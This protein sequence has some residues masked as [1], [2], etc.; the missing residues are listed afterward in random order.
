MAPG[1][2]HGDRTRT[3]L[4]APGPARGPKGRPPASTRTGAGDYDYQ[5]KTGYIVNYIGQDKNGYN[6]YQD[7]PAIEQLVT[8]WEQDQL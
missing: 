7:A 1:P 5:D 3:Q 6:F 4:P 2:A 8:G